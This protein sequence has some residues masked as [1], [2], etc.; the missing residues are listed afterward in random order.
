MWKEFLSVQKVYK[1]NWNFFFLSY[2]VGWWS[3]GCLCS[4]NWKEFKEDRVGRVMKTMLRQENVQYWGWKLKSI[5][6]R[7]TETSRLQDQLL[8]C[9][10]VR[11]GRKREQFLIRYLKRQKKSSSDKSR[12]VS[13]KTILLFNWRGY[14]FE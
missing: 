1:L 7:F 10:G 11:L 9:A 12:A 5:P 6:Y 14:S 13:A 2:L 4:K 8:S 3:K